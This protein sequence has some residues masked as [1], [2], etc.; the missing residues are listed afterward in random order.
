MVCVRDPFLTIAS[1]KNTFRPE[2]DVNA[3]AR[4]WVEICRFGHEH[5]RRRTVP[6][7]I[8]KLADKETR[9][10]ATAKV[11]QTIGASHT[12]QTLAT[13]KELGVIHKVKEDSVRSFQFTEE[14]KRRMID[15]VYGLAEWIE[16]LGYTLPG[17]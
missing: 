11:L 1:E 6:F 13:A 10:R 7:Q 5:D 3:A 4:L 17:G 8:D 2:L 15:E 12:P 16:R 9:V 14:D